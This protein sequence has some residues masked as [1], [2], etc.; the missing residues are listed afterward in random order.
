MLHQM[1]KGA[2]LPAALA[3]E[4]ASAAALPDNRP[5]SRR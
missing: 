1:G 5:L 4:H 3:I 2:W